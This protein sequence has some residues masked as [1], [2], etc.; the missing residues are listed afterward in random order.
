MSC[1]D[2]TLIIIDEC[3]HTQKGGVYNKIM[4][5]YL[6]QKHKNIK[7]KKVQEPTVPL[8]QILGL[9][10]S[11]GVGLATKMDKAEEH[12]LRVNTVLSFLSGAVL[13]KTLPHIELLFLTE[14]YHCLHFLKIR[15][16]FKPLTPRDLF[17]FALL[18]TPAPVFVV[19]VIGA[20]SVR[21]AVFPCFKLPL[22][23]RKP[24]SLALL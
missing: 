21:Q 1:A 12:I 13:T 18:L 20:F 24:E 9:T 14:F 19:L 11:P 3:H 8:P 10:A 22:H 16:H 17:T 5:R 6:K 2:L 23:S 7:L 15:L 4:M